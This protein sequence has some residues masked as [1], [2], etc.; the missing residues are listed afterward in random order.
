MI[1]GEHRLRLITGGAL[2]LV[3]GLAVWFGGRPL[4]FLALLVALVGLFEF[5]SLFW[6][7][8][9]RPIAKAIGLAMGAGVVLSHGYDPL[10]PA[11]FLILPCFLAALLFLFS[12]GMGEKEAKLGDFAPLVFGGVY[13]PLVLQ[14]ALSFGPLEQVIC[15]LAAIGTDVGGYYAGRS[16]GKHKIWPSVS[17][18]KTWEGATGGLLLC[19]LL[20]VGFGLLREYADVALPALPL[21]AWVAVGIL[22]N[23]AAQL[24]DFFESALKRTQNVKDSGTILPGHGGLL[25]RIDSLLFVMPAYLVIRQLAG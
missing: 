13:I 3:L 25:D 4:Q 16:F 10:W 5:Y 24:G 2:A 9:K 23:I 14:L 1:L 17:P 15:V 19:V 22:L 6:P 18:K 11:L 12:Y 8:R 20:C 21:P 7:G